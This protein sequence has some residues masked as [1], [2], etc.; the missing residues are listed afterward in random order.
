MG[1]GCVQPGNPQSACGMHV[2]CQPKDDSAS[3]VK[4]FIPRENF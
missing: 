3:S 1:V 4:I 2:A